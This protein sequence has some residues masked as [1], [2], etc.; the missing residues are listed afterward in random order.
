MTLCYKSSYFV[1]KI[2]SS[3]M[4]DWVIYFSMNSDYPWAISNICK[5][6][7]EHNGPK[8][9]VWYWWKWIPIC[10]APMGIKKWW[11]EWCF[12]YF[13]SLLA[14]SFFFLV[15]WET[16]ENRRGEYW[17]HSMGWKSL[18]IYA[19]LRVEIWRG[20][21]GWIICGCRRKN[22]KVEREQR[23]EKKK[24]INFLL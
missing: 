13:F 2:C 3:L 15:Y 8:L 14:F 4:I 19:E 1:R 6:I 18:R 10:L 21:D 24:V 12:W 22:K 16:N 23:R 9:H 7:L 20:D 17:I 5:L 11:H